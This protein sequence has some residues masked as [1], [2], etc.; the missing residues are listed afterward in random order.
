MTRRVW[1]SAG[2]AAGLIAAGC[3]GPPTGPVPLKRGP[4]DQHG[5]PP[6]GATGSSVAKLAKLSVADRKLAEAQK[7][8]PA[9][10]EPLGSMGVPPKLTLNGEVVFVC[11]ASCVKEAE[12]DPDAT[13]KK[14]A[15]AKAK[16]N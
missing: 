13:L 14:V 16:A 8:C 9:S 5:P 12:K 7:T 1:I 11:C 4:G 3:D 2:V 6:D 10:G 15:E